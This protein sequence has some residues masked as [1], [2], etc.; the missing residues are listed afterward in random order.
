VLFLVTVLIINCFVISWI[1]PRWSLLMMHVP[2]QSSYSR[3]WMKS[4]CQFSCLLRH[5]QSK[6]K[7]SFCDAWTEFL[8]IRDMNT[9]LK[10]KCFTYEKIILLALILNF[11][12]F[13]NY[14]HWT[15]YKG[16]F[17]YDTLR[18]WSYLCIVIAS[19]KTEFDIS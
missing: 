15:V 16:G 12:I 10:L 17:E 3:F 4:H 9:L 2:M 6:N 5:V 14:S 11:H 8:I 1:L 18:N 19:I 7:L 13:Y